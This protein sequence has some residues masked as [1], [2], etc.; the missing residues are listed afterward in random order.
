VPTPQEEAREAVIGV[1]IA[2]AL[3][4]AF[5]VI[6][7]L[8]L[9]PLDRAGLGLTLGM[10]FLVL[11]LATWAMAFVVMRL[12]HRI[13]RID[14]DTN[15]SAWLLTN[16]AA[17]AFLLV[18]FSA[19]AALAVRGS[20]EGAPVWVAAILYVVG[21]LAS[22]MAYT[23]VSAFYSGSAYRYK[24]LPITAL[25]FVLFAAWPAAARFLFGWFFALG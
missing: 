5:V 8:L 13:F 24:N 21:L 22:W 18:V 23:L 14:D 17:S 16:L 1:W 10:G 25:S 19:F 15:F 2:D 20:A 9:W 12:V 11:H 7:T 6:V 3:V 4:L